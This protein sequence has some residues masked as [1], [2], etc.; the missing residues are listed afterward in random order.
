M[1]PPVTKFINTDFTQLSAGESRTLS[2][3]PFLITVRRDTDHEADQLQ[4]MAQDQV[5]RSAIWNETTTTETIKSKLET[6][7]DLLEHLRPPAKN[8][9]I[10]KFVN[11]DYTRLS[12]G[13][14]RFLSLG[15][16]LI[17][18]HREP[19]Y[20][21][22]LRLTA[23]DKVSQS[24]VWDEIAAPEVVKPKLET[25]IAILEYEIARAKSVRLPLPTNAAPNRSNAS[26]ST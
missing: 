13:Q 12:A 3:G 23:Q 22:Q 17:M 21:D 2:L 14:K 9:L 6:A 15:P 18:V 10:P 1:N 24:L 11:T 4:L 5:S 20:A 8:P 7:I 16:F 19:V 25:A 26:H